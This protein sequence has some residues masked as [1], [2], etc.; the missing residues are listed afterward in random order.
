MSNNANNQAA[1]L[2]A[3]QQ[4]PE[5]M[6]PARPPDMLQRPGIA[7][8]PM[9]RL[10][11]WPRLPEQTPVELIVR[12]TANMLELRVGNILPVGIWS[13]LFGVC[14][15][16]F[17]VTASV[18]MLGSFTTRWLPGDGFF[19]LLLTIV[20]TIVAPGLVALIV[21]MI[22]RIDIQGGLGDALTV[23]DRNSRKVRQRASKKLSKGEWNWDDLHPYI[24][25]RNA[26]SRV[27]QVLTLVEL[28]E[29]MQ[30]IQSSVTVEA[31]GMSPQPLFHTYS[32][33]REF[34]EHGVANL[35]PVKLAG[36]PEPA[37][38]S[39]MP[40]WFFWLPRPV[41]KSI[42]AFALLLFVWPIV[43]WSRIV[44][45]VLPYSRWPAEFERKLKASE[46]DGT[47][48]EKAWLAANVTPAQRPPVMA[49]AA[50][51]AAVVVS[52]PGWWWIVQGYAAGL[53]KFW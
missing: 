8:P 39:S 20:P 16:P 13:L 51:A 42:W 12:C 35:P 5:W 29:S 43:V 1:E 37:W 31:S 4:Q 2:S 33:L 40:P 26:I 50:F 25:N 44:R 15:L 21:F 52:A 27:N 47:P 30:K 11:D 45:R 18:K 28:D 34:M 17:L 9:T 53:A 19:M 48:A 22:Y 10:S 36:V 49:Y 38:Y 24:E 3:G 14:F 6:R 7:T 23:F 46:A 41:A 32:F